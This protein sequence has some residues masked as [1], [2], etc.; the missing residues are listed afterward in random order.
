[1]Y[2]R[3]YYL[4]HKKEYLERNR[5][6]R[7]ENK[8][9]FYELVKKSRT[10]KANKLRERGEIYIW[11]TEPEKIKLYEKRQERIN[12]SNKEDEI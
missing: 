5:K 12:R 2:N 1:M 4:A 9:R 8:E 7:R 6:W 10:K 3:E 11:R